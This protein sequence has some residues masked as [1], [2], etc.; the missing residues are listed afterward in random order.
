MTT[1]VFLSYFELRLITFSR[2]IDADLLSNLIFLTSL[3]SDFSKYVVEV[4]NS[5]KIKYGWVRI[6]HKLLT[7]L[8]VTRRA[9][10]TVT[11]ALNR[12]VKLGLINIR[13]NKNKTD[14]TRRFRVKLTEVSRH[15]HAVNLQDSQFFDL[16][17]LLEKQKKESK[18]NKEL[19]LDA[20]SCFFTGMYTQDREYTYDVI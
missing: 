7:E 3:T 18:E 11:N 19:Y 20:C 4:L 9:S 17:N 5:E 15:L 14:K 2:D 10:K 8:L 1:K 13:T 12:L 6:N 16:P